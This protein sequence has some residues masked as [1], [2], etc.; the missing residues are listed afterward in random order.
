M[1][2]MAAEAAGLD[3]QTLAAAR[4]RSRLVLFLGVAL[5]STGQIAAITVATIVGQDLLGSPALAGAPGATVVL[6]AA[7][8]AIAL[9]SLMARRGRREG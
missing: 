3:E 7:T 5:G 4:R 2:L 1:S 8:G 9:S 6:G